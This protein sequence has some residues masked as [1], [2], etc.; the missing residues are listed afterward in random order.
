[1]FAP[2]HHIFQKLLGFRPLFFQVLEL[3]KK[4]NYI[5]SDNDLD[6]II[7]AA[8]GIMPIIMKPENTFLTL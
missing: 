5:S 2:T 4:K 7:G 3:C 8:H 6:L 1:M